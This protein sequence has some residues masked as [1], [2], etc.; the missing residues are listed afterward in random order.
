MHDLSTAKAHSTKQRYTPQHNITQHRI[1][2]IRGSH[3]TTPLISQPNRQTK[4]QQA[5]EDQKNSRK[6][7]KN[8]KQDNN[9]LTRNK[10]EQKF[11]HVVI[12]K[13]P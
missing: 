3:L 13:S 10:N 1:H 6:V 7:E 2:S 9:S 5:A 11:S 4:S 8:C 12:I